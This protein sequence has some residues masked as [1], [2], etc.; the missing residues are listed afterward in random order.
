MPLCAAAASPVLPDHIAFSPRDRE[1]AKLEVS[2]GWL[3]HSFI[4]KVL[5]LIFSCK[6]RMISVTAVVYLVITEG[7]HVL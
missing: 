1:A 2:V 7:I 5:N 3:P 6:T 4:F